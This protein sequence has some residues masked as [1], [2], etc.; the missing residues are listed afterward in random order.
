MSE[1]VSNQRLVTLAEAHHEVKIA[2]PGAWDGM[3]LNDLVQD[4]RDA[5]DEIVRLKADRRALVEAAVRAGTQILQLVGCHGM[6][7]LI[8]VK[9][10]GGKL[11]YQ[12]ND[13][14]ISLAAARV[15]A[16]QGE[17]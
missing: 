7:T 1:R 2:G 8:G 4:L 12:V 15:L 5:R 3:D 16:E 11:T 17:R 13:A 6:T 14:N 9:V 10:S